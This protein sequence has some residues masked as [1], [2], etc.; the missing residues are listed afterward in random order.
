MRSTCMQRFLARGI[1]RSAATTATMVQPRTAGAA[2]STVVLQQQRWM[3]EGGDDRIHSTDI[4]F[5]PAESGWGASNKY[6]NNFES[7]FGSKTES[8]DD[9]RPA[10]SNADDKKKD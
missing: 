1:T 8:K 2:S 6:S 4:A 10:G 5:K 7:I 9:E 3:S